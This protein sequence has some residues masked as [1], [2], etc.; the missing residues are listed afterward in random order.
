M[1]SDVEIATDGKSTG[2][3]SHSVDKKGD[4]TSA[5][6]KVT[7]KPYGRSVL[8]E[9]Y[10]DVHDLRSNMLSKNMLSKNMRI[11]KKFM[12]QVVKDEVF[13]V[14]CARYY[15]QLML[16]NNMGRMKA[17]YACAK[18]N[19]RLRDGKDGADSIY[20]YKARLI[21]KW[22]HEFIINKEFRTSG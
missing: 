4:R 3:A 5:D 21:R 17:W 13:K 2:H 7:K 20:S 6:F 12:R 11:S 9:A 8:E 14:V 10:K 16:D 22:G 1:D 15:I 19:Y 18:A